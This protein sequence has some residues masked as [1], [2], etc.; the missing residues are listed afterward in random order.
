MEN[1]C[2]VADLLVQKLLRVGQKPGVY[3]EWSEAEKQAM[4]YKGAEYSSFRLKRDA[5][6]YLK[7]KKKSEDGEG[8]HIADQHD[9]VI[10]AMIKILTITLR[11]KLYRRSLTRRKSRK[12]RTTMS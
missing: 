11:M 1:Q 8:D 12:M 4:G 7:S 3:N 5:E 6:K 2:K 9:T 10:N